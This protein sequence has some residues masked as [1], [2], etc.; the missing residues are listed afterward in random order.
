MEQEKIQSYLGMTTPAFKMYTDIL[1]SENERFASSRFRR[2]YKDGE[3]F[4]G[5]SMYSYYP[6]FFREVIQLEE[7]HIK[8]LLKF[9]H[10]HFL[11]LFLLDQ[12][13]DSNKIRN[14]YEMVVLVRLYQEAA[15]SL[16]DLIGKNEDIMDIVEINQIHN[17]VSML[18]EKYVLNYSQSYKESIIKEYCINKYIY[19]KS[20]LQVYSL[21]DQTV[22]EE[23]LDKLNLSHDY[24]A[25][26]R[27]YLDDLLDYEEDF[28][29]G[30]FNIYSYHFY[31]KHPTESQLEEDD[32]V[33][34]YMISEAEKHLKNAVDAL[35]NLPVTGWK[36]YLESYAK[37][38]SSYKVKQIG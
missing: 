27:Q 31:Q 23:T 4:L 17:D 35:D 18:N 15:Y 36:R 3:H 29:E 12:I 13:Y 25:I 10:F 28:N 32:E 33:V 21:F 22:K 6:L 11:S 5:L 2:F 7:A 9:S 16:K 30:G 20:A 14:P 26:G 19:A 1:M 8:N 37:R 34:T 24:F 38:I